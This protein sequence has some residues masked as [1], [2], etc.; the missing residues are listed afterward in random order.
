MNSFSRG[1]NLGMNRGEFFL[2]CR[3]GL[4]SDLKVNN[5]SKFTGKR[6]AMNGS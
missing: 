4:F 3:C 1:F 5:H 6:A 2:A